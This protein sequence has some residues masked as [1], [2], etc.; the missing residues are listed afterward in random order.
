MVLTDSLFGSKSVAV[1]MRRASY[2]GDLFITVRLLLEVVEKYRQRASLLTEVGDD[3]A[4]RP[5]GLLNL[6]V[7]VELGQSA[8]RSQVLAAVDHDNG[9]FALGAEGANELLVLL[10]LAVLGEAAESGRAAVEGLGALVQSLAKSIVDEGLLQHLRWR[11]RRR[12]MSY[13]NVVTQPLGSA[14]GSTTF[15]NSIK[16]LPLSEHPRRSSRQ[17]LPPRPPRPSLRWEL[18]RQ[19]LF[20]VLLIDSRVTN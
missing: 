12:A 8:P 10:V 19:P 20:W 13:H 15:C 2:F 18:L 14:T 11:R 16:N 5:D 3:R 17:P 1:T 7:G 6:S 4:A 9:Y